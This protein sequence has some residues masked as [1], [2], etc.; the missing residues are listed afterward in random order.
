MAFGR[1]NIPF[2]VNFAAFRASPDP[3][4]G[5]TADSPHQD[6]ASTVQLHRAPRNSNTDVVP[7]SSPLA[8]A[9]IGTSTSTIS[10]NMFQIKR[11]T[12]LVTP[13]EAREEAR[14]ER[15]LAESRARAMTKALAMTKA[16]AKDVKP[17]PPQRLRS[18]DAALGVQ[19]GLE[20][21]GG[22]HDAG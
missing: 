18:A 7:P 14:R 3:F 13:Q 6:T 20:K 10:A 5:Q 4:R 19:E 9:F 15:K 16:A 11:A 2:T 17:P 21:T 1:S 12:S 8:F 22:K